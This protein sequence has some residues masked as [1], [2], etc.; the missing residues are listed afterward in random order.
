MKLSGIHIF[1]APRQKVW[2]FLINPQRLAKCMPG[3]E[4]LEAVGEN[5]YSGMIT[6]GLAAVKGVYNGK[7]KLEDLQPP[8]HYKLVLDGKGKQGFIKGSG[9]LDLEEQHDHTVLTYKG[10]IQVGGPLASVGQRMIDGAAKMLIGQF[11]TAL[12]AEI[13]AM[14]GEAVRQGVLLNLWR[15]L[16]KWSRALLAGVLRKK[17]PRA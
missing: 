2:G 14:P 15:S 17:Q 1:P 6:V 12:E 5:E 16:L 8:A 9:T 10:D 3:C 7:V 11:F 13:N 4:K